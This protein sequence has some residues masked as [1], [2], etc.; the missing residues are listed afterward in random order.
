MKSKIIYIVSFIAAFLLT[1]G[2]IFYLNSTYKNIFQFDFTSLPQ[3]VNNASFSDTSKVTFGQLKDFM[4]NELKNELIDSLRAIYAGNY[5]DTIYANQQVDSV[6]ID[7]L[8]VLELALKQKNLVTVKQ[9]KP[10]KPKQVEPTQK[11]EVTSKP[12][13]S[14]IRWTK[15]TAKLYESMDPQQAAKIIQSYSDNVARDIIYSMRQK[16]AAQVLSA[17]N[18]ETANRITLAK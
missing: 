3:K 16:S 18:P 13:T 15:E 17:L 6:L 1:T 14:Y 10:I 2:L 7:S 8:R 4:Q 9:I 5:H 11:S 12:D